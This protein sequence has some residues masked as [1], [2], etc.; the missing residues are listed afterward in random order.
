MLCGRHYITEHLEFLRLCIRSSARN[1]CSDLHGALH[2]LQVYKLIDDMKNKMVEAEENMKSLREEVQGMHSRQESLTSKVDQMYEVSTE[3]FNEL[4]DGVE[5]Q[6]QL[7]GH[8]W[9]GL[10][11]VGGW[12]PNTT[13]FLDPEEQ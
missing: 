1:Q 11:R 13:R 12:I 4:E 7:T 3:F 10:A 5:Q 6:Q 8:L 9:M 2:R